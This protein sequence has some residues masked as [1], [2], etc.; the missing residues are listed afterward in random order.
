MFPTAMMDVIFWHGD[1]RAIENR[2]F[3]HIVPNEYRIGALRPTPF[4][5]V[6]IKLEDALPPVPCFRVEEVDPGAATW[7][8]PTLIFTEIG[9]LDEHVYL[10][11]SFVDGIIIHALDVRINDSNQLRNGFSISLTRKYRI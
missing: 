7:P 3:V 1:L 4:F 6:A 9:F 11:G 8:T 5:T 10:L 2:R